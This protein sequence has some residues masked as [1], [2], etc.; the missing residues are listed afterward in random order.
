[1][2]SMCRTNKYVSE[3]SHVD[4]EIHVK[5]VILEKLE[6]KR[7]RYLINKKKKKIHR[8]NFKPLK[9]NLQ[10]TVNVADEKPEKPSKL[11]LTVSKIELK[12]F[13]LLV[14]A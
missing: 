5:K 3:Q 6:R 9:R 11:K 14:E 4:Y 8:V 12:F 2:F 1:M 13:K 10:Q 7:L